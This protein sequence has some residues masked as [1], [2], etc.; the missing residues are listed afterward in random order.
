MEESPELPE[1]FEIPELP[2]PWAESLE[3]FQDALARTEEVILRLPDDSLVIRGGLMRMDDLWAAAE[4]CLAEKGFYG[5]SVWGAPEATALDLVQAGNIRHGKIRRS[6][7]GR[8][9]TEGFPVEP[10]GPPRH[11]TVYLGGLLTDNVLEKFE[12][13][14]DP[15]EPNPGKRP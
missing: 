6:T 14:F 9:R 12:A 8:L 3:A 13:A 2:E 1:L 15:P 10:T 11:C 4:T 7:A 5:L